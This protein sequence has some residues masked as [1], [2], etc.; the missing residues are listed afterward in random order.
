MPLI[1]KPPSEAAGRT[2][3]A[4]DPAAVFA[5]LARGSDD[6]RW[7]AARAA[8]DL[9]DSV[10]A[11]EDA[12]RRER[13]PV[14]REALFSALAHLASPQSVEAVL[15]F[16]R[17]DDALIRTEASDALLAMKGVVWSYV[18]PLLRDPSS[19]VRILACGLVREMPGEVAVSLCCG[20]LDSD[21]EPNV[22]AAAV[23]VLAEVGESSALPVLERCAKRFGDTPFLTFS[24]QM[25]IERV[26]SQAP[27]SRA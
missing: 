14:V 17:S 3:A 10:P 18:A 16:L 26:R 25:A 12:L 19:D 5:A 7:A 13:S 20:V 23:D 1:R 27:N 11:L 21:P 8:V 22:C 2:A 15:P 9:P 24:I 4:P 6:E